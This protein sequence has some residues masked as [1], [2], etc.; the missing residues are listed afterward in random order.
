MTAGTVI[1]TIIYIT[2]A[3]GTVSAATIIIIIIAYRLTASWQPITTITTGATATFTTCTV[4]PTC[5]RTYRA[6]TFLIGIRITVGALPTTARATYCA[7][8]IASIT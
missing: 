4:V 2:C 6:C 8:I 1:I 5:A 3:C 7:T